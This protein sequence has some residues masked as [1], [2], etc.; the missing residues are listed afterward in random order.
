MVFDQDLSFGNEY[1]H[2]YDR[3]PASLGLF[4]K[5]FLDMREPATGRHINFG[6]IGTAVM[7]A[8]FYL[9]A[10]LGVKLFGGVADG[11]SLP[12]IAAVSYA[13]ALFGFLGFLLMH[14]V[15]SAPWRLC[16]AVR[17]VGSGRLVGGDARPLLLDPGPRLLPC[18]IAPG[19]LD[20]ALALVARA[21]SREGPGALWAWTF[22]GAAAGLCA[23]VREQDGLFLAAPALDL[24]LTTVRRR[25]WGLGL[26][27]GAAMTGAALA[28]F[29][30]QLAV[31]RCSPVPTLPRRWSP[32]RWTT[33]ARISSK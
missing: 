31:Y 24:A 26:R 4:K 16:G 32:A 23:L 17:G 29:L 2:F 5:T 33:P 8:P 27:R 20:A 14:D 18:G 9:L 28:M 1:Q 30:P 11:Y 25:E 22:V 6:P 10:H 19:R 15:A 7:W 21:R 13:S 12:Y 3:D